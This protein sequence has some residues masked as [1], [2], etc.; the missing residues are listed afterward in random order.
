MASAT[1]TS[2]KASYGVNSDTPATITTTKSTGIRSSI[3]VRRKMI[4]ISVALVTD[5]TGEVRIT[6]EKSA[7]RHVGSPTDFDPATVFTIECGKSS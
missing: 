2:R 1:E 4:A 5:N 6:P 3:I 7:Y